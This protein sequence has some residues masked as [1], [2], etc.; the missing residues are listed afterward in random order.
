MAGVDSRCLRGPD[1]VVDMKH[2]A[3]P[4]WERGMKDITDVQF[5]ANTH[6]MF[7][8]GAIFTYCPWCGERLKNA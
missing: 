7:W 3:C 5:F 2:C 4:E 6:G 8:K 1:M